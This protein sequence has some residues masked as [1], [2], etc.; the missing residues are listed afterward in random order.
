MKRTVALLG[1]GLVL[2]AGVAVA[3][4]S[5]TQPNPEMATNTCRA[6]CAR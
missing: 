1:L 5:P 6:A 3:Q 4:Q 2:F